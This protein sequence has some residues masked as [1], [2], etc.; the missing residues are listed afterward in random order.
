M[1]GLELAKRY[2]ETIG[3]PALEAQL[4]QLLP[5]MAIGLAGEGSECFGFDDRQ[6]RDH[7]WG[8]AFCIWLEDEDYARY[9][10]Q[11]QAVY[12]S[13]PRE[14]GGFPAR[15]DGPNSKGR[16]GVLS[17]SEWYRRYTGMA[18]GPET[19]QQWRAVPEAFLATATNGAVFFDP[20]GHFSAIR[21][22]LLDFYPEDVRIK[23]IVARTA[24]MA[25]AGQYNY[26]RCSKRGEHVAA[27]LALA[28]FSRSAMSLTYLL[29][30]RYAPFYKWM[31]RGLRDL[32]V[33][34]A[35][36]GQL[37]RLS[38]TLEV[39]QAVQIIEGICLTVMHELR[40]Q[41]L[42]SG[43]SDF[44]LDH[45]PEMMAHIQDPQLRQTHIMKE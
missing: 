18:E 29:N 44:L 38:R 36:H 27:Q 8:A 11:V 15:K 41:G 30:R 9:G 7:D 6:S 21:E 37:D 43:T 3:R 33:L 23:K 28:E 34:P 19:L 25:Q 14:F 26:S 13:L 24:A 16:I 31:H 12:E 22:K 10:S 40:R 35:M 2:Y 39:E 20:L 4:P 42:S 32:P 17:T 5:R 45:C 1:T